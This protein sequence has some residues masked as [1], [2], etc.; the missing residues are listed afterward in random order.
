EATK[1]LPQQVTLALVGD[2]M[3]GNTW[4]ADRLPVSDGK[5]LFDDVAPIFQRADVTCGNLEGVI[6]PPE[7]GEPRKNPESKLA[8][9]FKMPPRYVEHLKNAGFDFLSL[10]NNHIYDFFSA[11][12][13]YTEKALADAQI[14]FA[15]AKDPAKKR[16]QHTFTTYKEIEGVTY[17][18]AAFGTEHY[19]ASLLDYASVK[20]IVKEM[21]EKADVVIVYFHGG[22]E[23]SEARHL[24]TG[25][26]YFHSCNRGDLR[27]FTHLC[28]DAGADVVFG[29]GPHVVRAIELYKG[30][31]IAYSLGN[32]CTCGMGIVGLTGLAPCIT[33]D[34]NPEDGKF[35]SGKI[36]AFR[37]QYMA[38][39]KTDKRGEAIREI[40]D[41]T[42]S[43][44]ANSALHIDDDGAITIKQQ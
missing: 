40:R 23:G 20:S 10:A 18:F 42:A 24:P 33:V 29:S 7:V 28:I 17:G 8:F 34:I 11:P 26:E 31:F 13:T 19:N 4:P 35:K 16:N 27:T 21:R 30:H 2:I 1:S 6:A 22:A 36:H 39:P 5:H 14:G 9:M 25:V 37:Q 32:F 3:M 44:I 38:G 43:D 12:I 15:G 41:L